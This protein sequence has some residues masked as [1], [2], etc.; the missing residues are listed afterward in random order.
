MQFLQAERPLQCKGTHS[1]CGKEAF[2]ILISPSLH[3]REE[4]ER[5]EEKKKRQK[6]P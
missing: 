3:L 1:A 5:K 6:K 4:E 2:M